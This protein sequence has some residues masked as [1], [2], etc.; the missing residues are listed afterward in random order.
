MD[1]TYKTELRRAFLL[2]K[3]PEPLNRAS[4]HLQIFDNYIAETRLRLR[5][6][7]NPETKEWTRIL[8]QRF[9][10]DADNLAVW[11]ISQIVLSETEYKIFEKF[12]GREIRKNRYF[13]GFNDRPFEIDVYLGDLWGLNIANVCFE[14]ENDLENFQ[15]PPF[16]IIEITNSEFFIGKSLV[17]KTFTDVQDEFEKLN[18]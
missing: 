16:A 13:Y 11:K 7:R 5:S 10:A 15:I 9:P 6:I 1:K 8:E 17:E 14:N 12:E 4:R 3:L 2:E 18:S